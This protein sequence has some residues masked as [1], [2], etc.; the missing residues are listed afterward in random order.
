MTDRPTG[1]Q[2]TGSA[3]TDRGDEQSRGP[4]LADLARMW[5]LADP[6]PDGLVARMQA[7][8]AAEAAD[9][10]LDYELLLLVERSSVGAGTR[11][12]ASYTLRFALDEVDLLLRPATVGDGAARV[13]RLD[14]WI[15]PPEGMRVRVQLV[16]RDL[17]GPREF[18]TEVDANGRFEFP[19]LPAG[20]ARLWLL[21]ADGGRPFATP[22][23]EI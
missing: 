5:S 14:G 12:T 15:V 18:D 4:V 8:V 17:A 11:A 2:G 1:R 19:E 3:D 7:A 16:D 6:V 23:F 13:T 10:D 9:A 22:V 21:P 20:L